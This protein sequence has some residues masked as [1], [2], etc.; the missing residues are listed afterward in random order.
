MNAKHPDR[1]SEFV[2]SSMFEAATAGPGAADLVR[3][4]QRVREQTRGIDLIEFAPDEIPLL[5]SVRSRTGG[6]W[7]RV[8]MF[9]DRVQ[10]DRVREFGFMPL[11]DPEA[12]RQVPWTMKRMSPSDVAREIDKHVQRAARHDVLSG[13][14]V[15]AKAGRVLY[16]RAVGFAERSFRARNRIDTK[17]HLGSASKMF[18]SIGIA[19]LVAQGRLGFHTPLIEAI[20]DYPNPEVARQVE[21][22]HLLS[23]TAGL[24]GLFDR[25]GFDRT[26]RY[27]WHADHFPLFADA[28]LLFPPGTR[29]SYSNEG[30]IV[31]GAVLEALTSQAFRDYVRQKILI[32]AG[33]K[34]TDAY[35]LD[36]PTPNR[37]VGY[38]RS[39]ED[40]FAM[41]PRRANWSFL[42]AQGNAA[43]GFYSTAPDLLRFA[44][45][46]RGHRFLGPELT[47]TITRRQGLMPNYGYG[48]FVQ[49]VHGHEAIGHGGGGPNSG[50]NVELKMFR[51]GSWTVAVLSNYDAPVAQDLAE[52]I[53]EL[54]ALQ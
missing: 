47:D 12:E 43:G 5:F 3:K 42:G 26:R 31:L 41:E 16:Q 11:L 40:P 50:V 7:A 13:V 14:V 28:P 46:L 19:Q 1:L 2:N 51:D 24:G 53:T 54:V 15:V 52:R 48:F 37:A 45:A 17:F 49:D 4:L 32:P 39:E 6:R 22:H 33:M 38:L 9:A 35:P 27:T 30:Y 21:I 10:T 29:Y 25:P 20:P 44:K 34:E 36:D 8:Y 18:T 23:H